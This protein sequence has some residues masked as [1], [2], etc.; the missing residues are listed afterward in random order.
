[1]VEQPVPTRAEVTDIFQAVLDGSNAVMLSVES[2][3]GQFPVESVHTMAAVV[4]FAQR[5]RGE[6][7]FDLAD[8][9]HL[10]SGNIPVISHT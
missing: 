10:L 5:A 4:A 9:L 3:A 6:Q 2:A 1:M 7:P 8:I